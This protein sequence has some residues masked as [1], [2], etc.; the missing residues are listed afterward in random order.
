[1]ILALDPRRFDVVVAENLFGDILSDEA[2]AIAGSLGML[3]SASVGNGPGLF[4]PV[5][6]SAP[7]LAG[8]DVANPV[9]AIASAAMLLRYAA[10]HDA[11]A[12]AI[13]HA[14]RATLD[15]GVR[16]PD[17]AIG[18]TAPVGCRAMAQAI[19]DPVSA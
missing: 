10:N 5:H 17:I 9:G 6:G 13:E 12:T 7:S 4:E 1:M 14:I 19:A 18:G 16:T 2:G 15:A 11:A 3:P 8:K